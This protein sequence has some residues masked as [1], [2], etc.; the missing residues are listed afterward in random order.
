[1]CIY[2]FA[3][4]GRREGKGEMEGWSDFDKAVDDH[5]EDNDL[6]NKNNNNDINN[7]KKQQHRQWQ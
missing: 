7:S 2:V 3:C 4:D 5:D 1:M 6:Y